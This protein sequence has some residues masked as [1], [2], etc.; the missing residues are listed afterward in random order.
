[1]VIMRR[2]KEVWKKTDMHGRKDMSWQVGF[3][4]HLADLAS[5]VKVFLEVIYKLF[6]G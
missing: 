5:K 6:R 1:M 2:V 3:P 4:Q